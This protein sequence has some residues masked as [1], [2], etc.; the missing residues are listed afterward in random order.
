[1]FSRHELLCRA[2][3]GALIVALPRCVAL[4]LFVAKSK[5]ISFVIKETTFR[6]LAKRVPRI[7]ILLAQCIWAGVLIMLLLLVLLPLYIM[8]LD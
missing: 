2:H 8:G 3:L 7:A 4:A 6:M 5:A 1:M